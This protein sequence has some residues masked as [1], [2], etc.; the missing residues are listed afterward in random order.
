M[1]KHSVLTQ[2]TRLLM[3]AMYSFRRNDSGNV[4]MMFALAI[5]AIF[6]VV[7]LALD[8]TRQT[9]TNSAAQTLV[10]SVALAL[11]RDAGTLSAAQLSLR[12]QQLYNGQ[13]GNGPGAG[14]TVTALYTA[15]PNKTLTINLSASIPT[16]FGQI[17]GVATLPIKASATVPVSSRPA[18]IALVLDNTGSMNGQGKLAALK[19]AS[20]NL[21]NEI[22]AASAKSAE[23]S[24]VALVP[25]AKSVKIGTASAGAGWLDWTSFAGPQNLWQGCVTD[26]DQPNDAN[27]KLPGDDTD[28]WYPA[29]NCNTSELMPLTSDWVALRNR[30]NA[31]NANGNTNI[32]IG[33][34]WGFNML[35][36]GAP[37]STA[38]AEPGKYSNYIILLT[39]GDNTQNRWTFSSES[40]D[41]RTL[42]ACTKIKAAGVKVFTVRVING[43]ENLL[44]TCATTPSMYYN[45]QQPEDLNG[46]FAQIGAEIKSALFLS[47]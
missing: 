16:T 24:K 4:A 45:V 44:R 22:E 18:Q 20:V 41:Q 46:V 9:Q 39:D 34:Q 7:A 30:L 12:A 14:L 6:G 5:V 2:K 36:A 47:R 43:N 19:T 38:S 29:V 3:P 10:D 25:F 35:T 32:T 27:N 13:A 8:T 15:S 26:R 23:T 1:A 40:I 37:L 42:E 33:L 31:M 21:V 17:F 11:A 28:T